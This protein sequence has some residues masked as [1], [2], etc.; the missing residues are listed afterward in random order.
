MVKWISLRSSEPSLGVRIPPEAQFD[1][2]TVLY[3]VFFCYN[4]GMHKSVFLILI[5]MFIAGVIFAPFGNARASS[6]QKDW[7]PDSRGIAGDQ[8]NFEWDKDNAEYGTVTIDSAQRRIVGGLVP[9]GRSCDDPTTTEINEAADCSFCSFFYLFNG[10]VKWVVTIIVPS[11][12]VLLIAIGGFM[13]AMSRGNPG[14]SQKG[15]DILIWTLAGIA[16]MFVGW[17]VLNSLLSGIGVMKW[18]GLKAETGE[19]EA[20]V[21][22]NTGGHVLTDNDIDIKSD[23]AW[24]RSDKGNG[25]QGFTVELSH[26]DWPEPQLRK[27]TANLENSIYIDKPLFE[28][29]QSDVRIR[30]KIGGWWQFSCGT[31]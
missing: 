6:N 12:A 17:A 31:E 27:I 5:F 7:C 1:L 22:H 23:K 2:Y 28:S 16:V 25:L 30:Y 24:E 19:F 15:K 20:Y 4:R 18:T 13:L 29:N 3:T 26:P 8:S 11:I 14:Q 21:A 10:I 9:C